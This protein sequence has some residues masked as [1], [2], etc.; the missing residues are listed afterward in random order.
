[1]QHRLVQ[2]TSVADLQAHFPEFDRSAMGAALQIANSFMEVYRRENCKLRF[3]MQEVAWACTHLACRKAGSTPPPRNGTMRTLKLCT[4][5]LARAK[6]MTPTSGRPR[7]SPC[8]AVLNTLR[9]NGLGLKAATY[10]DARARLFRKADGI[11]GTPVHLALAAVLLA[12][13]TQSLDV[14]LEAIPGVHRPDPVTIRQAIR[15][16]RST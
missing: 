16:L 8:L 12:D 14:L 11:R 7:I 1:M 13:P 4:E 6:P 2:S 5:L 15:R 9:A 3:R 10:M